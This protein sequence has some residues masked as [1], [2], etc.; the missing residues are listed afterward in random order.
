MEKNVS[1]EY[2]MFVQSIAEKSIR[3][4]LK[5]IILSQPLT[6]TCEYIMSL[7]DHNLTV[8]N[9]VPL[10]QSPRTNRPFI[11][12][13]FSQIVWLIIFCVMISGSLI[14]NTS[15]I[16][17]FVRNRQMRTVMNFFLFNLAFADLMMVTFNATFNFFYMIRSNWPFG[18][19]YCIIN[20]FIANLTVASSVFTIAALSI[21]R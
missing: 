18:K 17:I 3:D 14:G 9:D 16:W 13:T 4:C 10:D 19:I 12:S 15:I 21:E 1:S 7:I 8:E 2:L 11:P 20:N 5:S 6:K